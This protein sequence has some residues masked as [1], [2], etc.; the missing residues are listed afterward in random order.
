VCRRLNFIPCV[1]RTT[2]LLLRTE[3]NRSQSE[4]GVRCGAVGR[5]PWMIRCIGVGWHT[6][7]STSVTES[8]DGI[9]GK[10]NRTADPT[11]GH[12]HGTGDDPTTVL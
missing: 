4:D 2:P 3:K 8:V 6:W 10:W 9:P 12:G 7:A 1:L 5:G 11:T